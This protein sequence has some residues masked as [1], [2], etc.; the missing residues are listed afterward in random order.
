MIGL[1][2]SKQLIGGRTR[3]AALTRKQFDDSPRIGFRRRKGEEDEAGRYQAEKHPRSRH[4]RLRDASRDGPRYVARLSR[5]THFKVRSRV[6]H[7]EKS[8]RR[9]RYG[10]QP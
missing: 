1:Q 2:L 6:R 5:A 10:A 7:N 3:G 9:N 8:V 4:A